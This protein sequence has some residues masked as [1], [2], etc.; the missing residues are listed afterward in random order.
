MKMSRLEMRVAAKLRM[1]MVN[2]SDNLKTEG[3]EV[4]YHFHVDRK[5]CKEDNPR[6]PKFRVTVVLD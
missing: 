5:D 2:L 3:R 1:A 4:S 6:S